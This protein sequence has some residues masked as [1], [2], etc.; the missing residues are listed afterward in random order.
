MKRT[1]VQSKDR[2]FTWIVTATRG[3]SFWARWTGGWVHYHET[4]KTPIKSKV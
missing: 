2:G 4:Y 1:V 3:K